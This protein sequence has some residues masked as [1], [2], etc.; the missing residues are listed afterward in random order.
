[1]KYK[2]EARALVRARLEYFNAEYGFK[3]NRI[4]IK[5]HKSRWGSCSKKGNLNFNYRIAL[6]APHLADYIVVHELC[7]LG[8]LNHLVERS[9]PDWRKRRDEL[10]KIG[11][12]TA[13]LI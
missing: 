4:A 5:D 12:N 7:H 9:M 8:E 10:M 6:I 1:M 13:S 3:W 11:A 2:E